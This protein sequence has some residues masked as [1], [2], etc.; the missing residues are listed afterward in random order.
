MFRS[1]SLRLFRLAGINVYVHW[2]WLLVAFFQVQ[3]R[4]RGAQD[5]NSW[6]PTY[7]SPRWY[8][9]EYVSLFAIVLMHEFGHALACRQVGGFAENIV[10]WPL[11]GIALV[12]PPVRP[13][14]LLW[15]IVAGPLVNF[16]LIPVLGGL[17]LLG[18][19]FDWAAVNADLP[20]FLWAVFWING[21]LLLFNL[22]PIYPMDGGQILH[23]LLWFVL[24]RAESLLIVS[25]LGMVLGG[26][27][28]L[29]AL[30]AVNPW[31]CVVS[32]FV[33]YMAYAGFRQ[34][35][36]LTH[37]LSGPRRQE[38]ACP[39]CGVSPLIGNYW[40]CDECGTRFDT[41]HCRAQC[42]GCGKLFRVTRCPECYK[43]Y[44]IDEWFAVAAP[45]DDYPDYAPRGG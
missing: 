1:G 2:T 37:I 44:P 29:L 30:L 27:A 10:L 4:A 26:S 25:I 11:G 45:R 34:G 32:A 42:P 21:W 24:G 14:P 33:V 36:A 40:T 9:I 13:G 20:L 3:Y 17:A 15:T 6:I 7:D 23:A 43:Q 38:A 19:H 12:R 31:L 28:F 39:S 18:D 16:L 22:I 8:W 35:R 5:G 41:F